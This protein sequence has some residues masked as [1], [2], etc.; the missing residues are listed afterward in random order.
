MGSSTSSSPNSATSF[1]V[2]EL[3]EALLYHTVGFVA[4]PTHRAQVLCHQIAPLCK[5]AQRAILLDEARSVGLWDAVL[6]GDYGVDKSKTQSKGQ[7]SCKRLRRS[8]CHQVRDAHKM[9]KDNTEICF[10]YLSEMVHASSGNKKDALA[11]PSMCGLL[12]EYGPHLRINH[13]VSSGGVYLVEVC[14]AR[15]AK[16]AVILKCVEELVERRGAHLDVQTYEAK[17]SSFTAL[18]VAAVRGMP[19]VVQYLLKQGASRD[20]KCS[21]RFRTSVNARKSVRCTDATALEFA[22]AMQ[23]ME[24]DNGATVSELKNVNKSIRM[25]EES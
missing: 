16:E 13:P 20:R 19:S 25:L 18:C 8:P 12:N 17:N 11:K 7:R 1:P 15:N 9:V 22:K 4:L 3:P 24:F 6:V 10:F 2:W 21:G 14:K 23:Q 5:A